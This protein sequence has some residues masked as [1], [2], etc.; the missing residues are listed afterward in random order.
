M[1]QLLFMEAAGG[2]DKSLGLMELGL[3]K[4]Y[5]SVSKRLYMTFSCNN[6]Q[7]F[8]WLPRMVGNYNQTKRTSNSAKGIML[9][10]LTIHKSKGL[11]F[12]V[13]LMPF[14]SGTIFRYWVREM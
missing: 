13:V 4:A 5:I 1:L 10:I 14:L 2:V 7:I 9:R 6:R 8:E 12:K 11:Q 3:E